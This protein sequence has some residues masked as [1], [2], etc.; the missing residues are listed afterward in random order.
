MT[1]KSLAPTLTGLVALLS[2]SCLAHAKVTFVPEEQSLW[3]MVLQ[4][5]FGKNDNCF[6]KMQDLSG[7]NDDICSEKFL[8][9][10]LYSIYLFLAISI[11]IPQI[12]IMVM[13][14]NYDGIHIKTVILYIFLYCYN[15]GYNVSR[16]TQLFV[17]I[18]NYLLMAQYA[19]LLL[20]IYLLDKRGDY[21]NYYIVFTAAFACLMAI[22]A[23]VIPASF[24]WGANIVN[25][26]VMFLA[27]YSQV[28]A[29]SKAKSTGIISGMTLTMII[30]GNLIKLISDYVAGYDFIKMLFG[31]E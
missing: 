6:Y 3:N 23:G 11:Q 28:R 8:S 15:I 18:D 30:L 19:A 10:S 17:F 24:Y 20:A 9:K 22:H 14:K 21:K 2:L 7:F 26:I 12:W 1:P 31:M 16:K 29:N 4:V 27:S 13:Q 25:L 5:W